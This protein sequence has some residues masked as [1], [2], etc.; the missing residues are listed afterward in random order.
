MINCLIKGEGG[1]GVV[2]KRKKGGGGGRWMGTPLFD[3]L[4]AGGS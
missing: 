2:H 1:R 3:T 4:A